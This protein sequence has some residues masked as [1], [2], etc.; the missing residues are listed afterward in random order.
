LIVVGLALSVQV[1]AGGV[2]G[3]CLKLTVAL[4]ITETPAVFVTV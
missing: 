2:T 3:E 4:Q 1:G